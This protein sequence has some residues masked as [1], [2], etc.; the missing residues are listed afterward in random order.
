MK[1]KP[2]IAIVTSSLGICALLAT[3]LMMTACEADIL[4]S[5]GYDSRVYPRPAP[6]LPAVPMQPGASADRGTQHAPAIPGSLPS[7]DEEV[8]V[9]VRPRSAA[10]QPR[11]DVP[12]SGAMVTTMP[13]ETKHVPIP[14]KHTEVD[15]S[16]AGYIAT[17]DVTQK[18]HNPYDAKI[19]AVY[20]FP[21]P[22]NA[23]VNG[24]VMQI[25]DRK[26]RGIIRD[27]AEAEKIY[28]DARAAGH[29]AALMTQ[30][31]PNIFTQKVAN[32]EP[33]KAIDVHIRYFHTLAYD[34]GWYEFVFPM[35]VGPRFN[36]P[37]SAD[38]IHAVG[39]GAQ[40]PGKSVSYLK[41]GERSGH[42]IALSLSVDAGVKVR[43]FASVNHRVDTTAGDDG[44]FNVA[45][46]KDDRLPNKDF[47][48]RYK[49][50]GD[51]PTAAML[52]HNGRGANAPTY[53]TL[54]LYPPAELDRLERH[55]VEMVFVLDCSGSM[56]GRPMEQSKKAMIAALDKMQPRDTFQ[57]IRFSSSASQ[58]GPAP[59][60]ATPDNIRD[61]K[62]YVR[63]L[64]G[65]GGTMMIEGIK[66]ALD[67][68]HDPERLRYVVFLTDGYIGNETEILG[69]MKKRIGSSRVFSF[70]VGSSP[71][72]YLMDRMAK[73]GRGAV[74]YLPL[75]T[76]GEDV[77]NAFFERVSHPAMADIRVDWGGLNVESVYPSG[78]LDL[79]VGRPVILTGKIADMPNGPATIRMNGVAGSRAIEVGMRINPNSKNAQHP[80]IPSV[81]ARQKIASIMDAA[82]Y[83]P[84][85][86]LADR[87]K[88]VALDHDLMSAYTAFVAVD[89]TR[90]T[91]GDSGTTVPV[92]VP[93][94]DGVSYDTTVD[95]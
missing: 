1:I 76:D 77:M 53:F 63:G 91:A 93:V 70:G 55:P 84:I 25:G 17:V 41:P 49:V 82:T 9:I 42:D 50:A 45:L 90:K 24:F 44:R 89:A 92:P 47:V 58:L 62:R 54:M 7:A 59:V 39:R 21:L 30:E 15:A 38:P 34:D 72:R 11:E 2:L 85:P 56:S 52:T 14:L 83:E 73:L 22:Q 31:R 61:A 40:A 23:A 20:V 16:I 86:D 13:G 19:E 10:A 80:A 88:R 60:S 6:A 32:I 95:E 81:W 75:E 26:I 57:V 51:Q 5:E 94:P 28:N 66:A 3:F 37:H 35:V 43:D 87:I 27:R 12:R 79:F 8:W 64:S 69:A 68:E 65:G 46:A 78:P 18:F 71:N 67:F 33:G 74:A 36:P 48:F 29:N 4:K